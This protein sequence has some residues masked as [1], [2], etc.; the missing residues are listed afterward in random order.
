M[1]TIGWIILVAAIAVAVIVV[2]LVIARMA[3]SRRR[4]HLQEQF[5]PEYDRTVDETGSRRDAEK[6]LQER[7][8]QRE[9][10]DIRPLSS[11]ARTRF[12]DEWSGVQQRFL[13]DP[14]GAASQAE[15]LVRRVMD[16][17]GYPPENDTTDR[18][19]LVSVDHPDVVDRY[20]HG[21]ETLD[22]RTEGSDERTENLRVA[23]V[24]FRSVLESLLQTDDE[25]AATR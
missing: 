8:R 18:A 21:R 4:E 23:M 14:E 5:G 20:R 15:R 25:L 3:S 22:A 16:E 7:E 13:D 9:Q 24:D 2:M 17:R 11:A 12:T 19:A 10:L 1:S 6:E